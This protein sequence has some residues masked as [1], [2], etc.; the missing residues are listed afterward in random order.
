MIESVITNLCS[1]WLH[2]YYV[3]AIDCIY[4]CVCT[5]KYIS[6]RRGAQE[7]LPSQASTAIFHVQPSSANTCNLFALA[8]ESVETY[9]RYIIY[10]TDSPHPPRA[11][12]LSDWWL[13]VFI[14]F[15][16]QDDGTKTV[17]YKSQT[18]TSTYTKRGSLNSR[19]LIPDAGTNCCAM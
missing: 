11:A 16:L 7:R 14:F 4:L 13:M 8:F 10:V 5:G 18:P 15:H 6:F 2:V 3:S 12:P 9:L 19:H 17:K 1:I